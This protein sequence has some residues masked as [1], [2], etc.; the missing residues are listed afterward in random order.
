M[1]GTKKGH[2]T[3]IKRYGVKAFKRATSR[4]GRTTAKRYFGKR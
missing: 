3:R 4:G 1:P 2:K